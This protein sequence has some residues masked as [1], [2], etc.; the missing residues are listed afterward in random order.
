MPNRPSCKGESVVKHELYN[1]QGRLVTVIDLDVKTCETLII[2]HE[3]V[4]YKPICYELHEPKVA[5][6]VP[7]RVIRV[8]EA[9]CNEA[10]YG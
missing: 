6:C 3:G 5:R 4:F 10:I 9:T 8:E 2:E 1:R 7:V